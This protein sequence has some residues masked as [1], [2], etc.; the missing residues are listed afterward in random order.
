MNHIICFHNPDEE[1]GWLSN[2]HP[3]SFGMG[4]IMFS[5]VEQYMMYEKAM[6]FHDLDVAQKILAEDNVAK[7]KQYGRQVADYDETV[8]NGMRQIIVYRGLLA[9]FS[10]NENLGRKLRSTGDTV[11]AE[12]AVHDRIWGIGLSMRDPNRFDIQKWR[13]QNLLGFALMQVRQQILKETH[14]YIN[15][16]WVGVSDIGAGIIL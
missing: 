6:L 16:K 4:G 8:W 9:K 11:L 7:V 13:G 14:P 15:D 12:C 5:G 10:Q 3:S 2:W 1:N